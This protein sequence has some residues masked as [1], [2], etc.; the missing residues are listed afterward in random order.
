MTFELFLHFPQVIGLNLACLINSNSFN[1]RFKVNNRNHR[2]LTSN[3][4]LAL[5]LNHN[6]STDFPTRYTYSGRSGGKI[7]PKLISACI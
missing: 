6:I 4:I 1:P 3:V 5:D 7:I 2:F